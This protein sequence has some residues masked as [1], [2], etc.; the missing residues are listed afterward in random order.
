MARKSAH[1]IKPGRTVTIF[2]QRREIEKVETLENGM[3]EFT[4][5]A[6]DTFR[7]PVNAKIEVS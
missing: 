2:G 3:I 4:D 7:R 6:G 5:T 1:M